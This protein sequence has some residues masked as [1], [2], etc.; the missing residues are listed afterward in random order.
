M[1]AEATSA[2]TAT[3]QVLNIL[4]TATLAT[5]GSVRDNTLP[6]QARERVRHAEGL[7]SLFLSQPEEQADQ[8]SEVRTLP[9]DP[10]DRRRCCACPAS[11]LRP[12]HIDQS[13]R[14]RFDCP[15]L[16]R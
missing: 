4:P 10:G 16:C 6:W 7:V 1:L 12:A 15:N 9:G 3:E 8:H 5:P 13:R 2:S 11:R 14:S